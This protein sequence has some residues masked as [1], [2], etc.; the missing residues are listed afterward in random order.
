MRLL[1]FLNLEIGVPA[2]T[3]R[4]I[5]DTAPKRYKVYE[6]PKRSGGTRT[7]AHPSRELKVL[8]RC[9]LHS[10]FDS[11]EPSEIATAYVKGRGIAFNAQLHK[12]NRWILKLDF[13]SFFHSIT[14]L[15]WDRF[16]R[17][18]SNLDVLNG[19]PEQAHKI[20]FWGI[21]SKQPKCLSIGAPTSP[22]VSNFVCLELD[23]WMLEQSLKLGVTVSRYADDITLS[24]DSQ[25]ALL[26]F[27]RK[28]AD[29]LDRWRGAR[30]QLNHEKRGIYGPGQRRMVTGIILT[31][32][33]KISIGRDRKREISALIHKFQL[34]LSSDQ[35]SLRAKGLLAF[36][37]SVEPTFS[38]S[39]ATKYGTDTI[40]RLMRVSAEVEIDRIWEL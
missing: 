28:L 25:R 39:M 17:G 18:Q 33:G 1:E 19:D 22:S 38:Q 37:S 30:L 4:R 34:G 7:I 15:D 21:G 10:V 6:I 40:H 12:D 13:K 26:S 20:L 24:S 36:A 9:L 11:I 8:Q 32:D 35:A 16:S 23:K 3:L 31:P 5:I 2:D 29:K 27:E 14:P